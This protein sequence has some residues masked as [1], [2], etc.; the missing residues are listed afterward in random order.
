LGKWGSMG[1]DRELS[2]QE[3]YALVAE[4]RA[5]SPE[6]EEHAA[7]EDGFDETLGQWMKAWAQEDYG[8]AMSLQLSD[9]RFSALRVLD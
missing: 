4:Y 6:E 5:T 3:F 1:S 8:R 9:R 2:K 7:K